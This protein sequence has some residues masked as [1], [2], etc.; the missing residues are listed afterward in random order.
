MELNLNP[1]DTT[2]LSTN[3][4]SPVMAPI[5]YCRCS[6]C[7]CKAT[8]LLNQVLEDTQVDDVTEAS[9]E[10]KVPVIIEEYVEH[11]NDSHQDDIDLISSEQS[12]SSSE[13]GLES[14]VSLI[15]LILILICKSSRLC[16][17]SPHFIAVSLKI[18]SNVNR[19]LMTGKTSSFRV[20]KEMG[21]VEVGF[22]C[23]V[24]KKEEKRNK[25]RYFDDELSRLLHSL[26]E[27]DEGNMGKLSHHRV[28]KNKPGYASM[29]ALVH[30]L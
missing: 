17:H 13:P 23:F 28:G 4:S 2:K 30:I 3:K 14:L 1:T 24:R 26:R 29:P 18:Y 19:T 6:N 8:V 22:S 10:E 12:G 5:L 16:S 21:Q 20:S 15:I 27:A 11:H 9:E 7:V 25:D